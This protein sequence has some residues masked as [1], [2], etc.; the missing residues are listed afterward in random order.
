MIKAIIK[1]K[2][3]IVTIIV[4]AA[5]AI[6]IPFF[7][8]INTPSATTNVSILFNFDNGIPVLSESKN[9]PIIQTVDNITLTVSSSTDT[10]SPGFSIQ[11]A[12]TTFLK[13]PKFSG[14]Y[15][16]D[17][18]ANA[19][20][21]ILTF[22]HNLTGLSLTFATTEYNAE[23]QYN[24]SALTMVAYQGA[25]GNSPVGQAS[26]FG[27]FDNSAYP[28]GTLSFESSHPFNVVT[29]GLARQD[30]NGAKEFLIDNV[31]IQPTLV[32]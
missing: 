32:C 12:D 5:L 15:I 31:L 30:Q 20:T 27:K 6:T 25:I 17:N 7:S 1:N 14:N 13:L 23:H 21:L 28:Q 24:S 16:Y 8:F 29:I 11:S 18:N 26:A 10:Y 3:F 19:K 22:D 9:T 2:I 4:V